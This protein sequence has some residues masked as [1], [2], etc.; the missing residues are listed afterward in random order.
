[1][2]ASEFAKLKERLAM[3]ATKNDA[4]KRKVKRM[5]GRSR[6]R[7]WEKARKNQEY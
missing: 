2:S 1:M 3:Q 6:Q 4:V 5:G 7:F